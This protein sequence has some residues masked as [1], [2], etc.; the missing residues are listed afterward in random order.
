MSRGIEY[1]SSFGWSAEQVFEVLVDR[2]YLEERLR[3]LGGDNELVEHAV[4]ESGARFRI[5]QAVRA[6]VIPSIA[7]PIVGGRLVIARREEWHRQDDG[8]FAGTV[9]AG[10]AVV[11]NAITAAQ[12]LRDLP[13]EERACEHVVEGD[14]RVDVPFVGGKLEDLFAGEV[15]GLLDS[16]HRF[17]VDWLSRR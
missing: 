14:V 5:N 2:D 12:R 7:R 3:A 6:E 1:R 4:T 13:S 15:R 10:A 9:T 8:S 17:T 16:E 11:P